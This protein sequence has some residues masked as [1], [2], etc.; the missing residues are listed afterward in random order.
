MQVPEAHVLDVG[1]ELLGVDAVDL[2]EVELPLSRPEPGPGHEEM[3][4]EQVH[5]LRREVLREELEDLL[6]PAR[7]GLVPAVLRAHDRAGVDDLAL[8][9]ERQDGDARLLLPV[10][11]GQGHHSALARG[12]HLGPHVDVQALE[13]AAQGEELLGVVVVARDEHA[14]KAVADEPGQEIEDELFRLGWRRGRVED[15]AGHEDGVDPGLLR[16]LG[17]L[18]EGL[19]VFVQ[20][21]AA[22]QGLADVPVGGVEETHRADQ[23]SARGVDRLVDAAGARRQGRLELIGAVGGQHEEQAA[24]PRGARPSR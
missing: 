21:A 12:T 8:G 18:A 17:H 1:G 20:A 5:R 13:Q 16:H 10:A 4:E 2:A 7:V 3:G 6:D 19:L 22:A 24:R 15:V 23:C 9:H 11:T 14:G